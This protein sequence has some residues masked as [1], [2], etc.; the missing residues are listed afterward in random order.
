MGKKPEGTARC[1]WTGEVTL[2]NWAGKQQ[3]T[4]RVRVILTRAPG[5][6]KGVETIAYHVEQAET[7]RLG[8]DAWF[9][10]KPLTLRDVAVAQA[11]WE[12]VGD[13][14]EHA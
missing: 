13:N 1:V 3:Q 10:A 8:Q 5:V 12:L 9:P 14:N 4:R 6:T 11:L 7:D 2:A